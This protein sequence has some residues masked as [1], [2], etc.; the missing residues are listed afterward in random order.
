MRFYSISGGVAGTLVQFPLSVTQQ[1]T[2]KWTSGPFLVAPN[3]AAVDWAVTNNDTNPVDLR[4]T[5]YKLDLLGA[6]VAVV[7]GP[8]SFS[9]DTGRTFHNGN[10][11]GTVFSVGFYYEVVV[12][13]SSD[14]VQAIVDQWSSAG[15]IPGTLISAG[16]FVHI[17]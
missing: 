10:N 14:N 13:S 9:L 12:E 6:K 16:Q 2:I 15:F 17:R 1:T 5:V 7:P 3:A 11:V 8:L 4:V